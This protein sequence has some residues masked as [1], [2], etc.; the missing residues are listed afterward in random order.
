PWVVL[1]VGWAGLSRHHREA[2]RIRARTRGVEVGLVRW[3]N[4]DRDA[5][6]AR[7]LRGERGRL[8][9]VGGIVHDCE[10][11]LLSADPA[12]RVDLGLGN[13]V[14]FNH[15]VAV[16]SAAANRHLDDTNFG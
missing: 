5:L 12:G 7:E 3:C 11:E 4:S 15:G 13:L 1:R 6:V 9:I 16:E 14:P 10:L 8:C 2:R